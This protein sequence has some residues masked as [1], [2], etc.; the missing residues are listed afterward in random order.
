MGANSY[1]VPP[2]SG[3]RYKDKVE[4]RLQPGLPVVKRAQRTDI[5]RPSA[6]RPDDY[7]FVAMFFPEPNTPDAAYALSEARA[8]FNRHMECHPGAQFS[9]HEHGG[10]CHVCGAYAR[11]TAIFYHADSNSYVRMGQDCAAKVGM[12]VEGAFRA[13]RTE[14]EAMRKSTRG[15]LLA[16]GKLAE[17]GLDRAWDIYSATER[18]GYRYEENT[19]TDIVS[20]LVRYGAI[21]DAQDAFLRKLLGQIDTRAVVDAERAA[22]AAASQHV[23]VVGDRHRL[24]L[25]VRLVRSWDAMMGYGMT[26]L[27]VC[28]D[29]GGNVVV[30]KGSKELAARGE[31]VT[32]I[33]TVAEHAEREGTKQTIIKR[34]KIVAA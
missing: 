1:T 2:F 18:S 15:K 4:T 14:A 30:Y 20:K 23:G 24:V 26:Y 16:K 7:E 34:P 8:T 27:H 10:T 32:V 31:T 29:E 17:S 5:H 11:T 9:G 3:A 33:A 12:G 22:K 19:I 25:R 6:I 21:S 13:A 28:E